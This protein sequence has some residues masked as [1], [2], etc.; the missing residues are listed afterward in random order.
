MELLFARE[1]D[2]HAVPKCKCEHSL[3]RLGCRVYAQ[4]SY[5][6]TH[7]HFGMNQ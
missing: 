2:D 6:L 7:A 5:T 1:S 3:S 4:T